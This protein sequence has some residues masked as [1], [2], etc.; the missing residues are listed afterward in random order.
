MK[1]IITSIYLVLLGAYLAM[2]CIG[3]WYRFHGDGWPALIPAG[4]F[5]AFA[6]FGILL[7]NYFRP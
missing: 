4:A 6:G 1:K 5:M 7:D 3:L 2:F